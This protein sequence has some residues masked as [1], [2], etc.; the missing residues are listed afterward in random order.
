MSPDPAAERAGKSLAELLGEE[1]PASIAALSE[2]DRGA[3]AAVIAE[4][5]RKQAGD[6]QDA[7]GEALRHV[8]FPVRGIVR[9]VLLG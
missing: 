9:K 7:F 5:R 3:L 4:A 2:A 8:P 6:L 1:P